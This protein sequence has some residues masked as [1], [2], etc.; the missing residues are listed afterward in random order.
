MN[1]DKNKDSESNRKYARDILMNIRFDDMGKAAAA[2]SGEQFDALMERS[3]NGTVDNKAS[4]VAFNKAMQEYDALKQ[5]AAHETK[6][7]DI[8]KDFQAAR[9]KAAEAATIASKINRDGAD[10]NQRV[11]KQNLQKQITDEMAKPAADRDNAKI[12]LMQAAMKPTHLL[13]AKEKTVRV[14]SI[15]LS[16]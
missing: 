5:K 12:E 16:R 15:E 8:V 9:S 1:A 3:L 6:D 13:N 11:V 10:D 4:M 2:Q 7:A 14:A